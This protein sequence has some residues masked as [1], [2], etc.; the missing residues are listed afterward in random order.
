MENSDSNKALFFKLFSRWLSWGGSAILLR[1]FD[2]LVID[3]DLGTYS[4]R[5]SEKSRQ[6][7]QPLITLYLDLRAF[8]L[9]LVVGGKSATE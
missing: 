3:P 5:F 2:Q 7:G 6:F 8:T 9:L 1:L 4:N